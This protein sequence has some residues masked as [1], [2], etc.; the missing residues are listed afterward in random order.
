MKDIF[1]TVIL[2]HA[3][4]KKISSEVG[5]GGFHVFLVMNIFHRG[6][7]GPPSRSNWIT[8]SLVQRNTVVS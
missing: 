7:Y 6:P 5:G 2:L 8:N 1:S 4:I 3:Q